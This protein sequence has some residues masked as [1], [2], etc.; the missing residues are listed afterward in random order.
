MKNVLETK[1]VFRIDE[2]LVESLV[3]H[4]KCQSEALGPPPHASQ[5]EV[6]STAPIQDPNFGLKKFHEGS[7]K[8][9]YVSV[10]NLFN[11]SCSDGVRV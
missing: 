6:M 5:S 9:L 10:P 11:E 1:N 3:D 4:L 2:S 8:R 7:L